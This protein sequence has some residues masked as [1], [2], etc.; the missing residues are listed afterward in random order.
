[1]RYMRRGRLRVP[2]ALEQLCYGDKLAVH[3]CIMNTAI[4]NKRFCLLWGINVVAVIRWVGV[5]ASLSWRRL[6]CFSRRLFGSF[7]LFSSKRPGS[8][9]N[10]PCSVP[11]CYHTFL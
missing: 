2:S 7:A 6:L 10:I 3:C 4:M 9:L 1:M 11:A 8:L 5:A